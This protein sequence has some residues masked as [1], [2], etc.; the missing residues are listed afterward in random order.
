MSAERAAAYVALGSNLGNR[1]AHLAGAVEALRA[2]P[3]VEVTA[4]SP[5]YETDPVGGPPQGAYLNAVVALRTE[6]AP[7]VL[8]ARLL[9]IESRAGRERGAERDA[10]RSLD[11]DLLLYADEKIDAPGLAVPHPR[12]HERAF[13][14]EPLAR[15]AP[16]LVHPVLGVSVAE[17]AA[18]VRDAEAVRRLPEEAEPWPSSR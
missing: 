8:L 6:L 18:R 3:G 12:L 10:P 9:E 5:V 14:L 13:V 16:E 17:L 2:L 1:G 7:E 4:L 11:L 15:L